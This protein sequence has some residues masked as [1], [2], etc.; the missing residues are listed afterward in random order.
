MDIVFFDGV[1][2]LCNH[3]VNFLLSHDNKKKIRF[4]PLQG[5]FIKKTKAASFANEQT[6]VFLKGKLLFTKSRAAIEAI[7]MLGGPWIAIKI[8]LIVPAFI[9]DFIYDQIA[10]RRYQIFGKTKACRVPTSAEQPYFLE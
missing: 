1:C 6:V 8:F 7:A 9:R 4:S 10:K 3:F 2:G 5:A